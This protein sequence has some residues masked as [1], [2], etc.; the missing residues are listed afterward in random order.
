MLA[1]HHR[2]HSPN[3][4][5]NRQTERGREREREGG[6]EGGKCA[7]AIHPAF[8]S[9]GPPPSSAGS[10]R[11]LRLLLKP[12][13]IVGR[14]RNKFPSPLSLCT[15]RPSLLSLTSERHECRALWGARDEGMTGFVPGYT[16]LIHIN[17]V[18]LDKSLPSRCQPRAS[19]HV[20]LD[21]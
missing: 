1:S 12:K 3:V 6:R 4:F 19:V 16:C 11:P 18:P 21:R 5:Q 10:P 8:F 2:W 17:A 13:R 7:A 15:N 14:G 20:D 9:K